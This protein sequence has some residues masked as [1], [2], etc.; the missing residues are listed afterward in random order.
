MI[1]Y[2]PKPTLI[3]LTQ[4]LFGELD[5][6]VRFITELKYNGDRLILQRKETGLFEF[7][8]RDG[9][10]LKYNPLD[11]LLEH[12]SSFKWEGYCVLDGELLHFKTKYI[13]HHVILFDA[14]I[15]NGE[16]L[17][18]KVFKERRAYVEKLFDDG[19]FLSSRSL[20]IDTI[21][22]IPDFRW[23]TSNGVSISPQ[24]ESGFK[25]IFNEFTKMDEIEGLVI[26]RLDAKLELGRSSS[27]VVKYMF[28][29]RKP[30]PT[31]R[32]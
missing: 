11:S 32:F 26:K 23:D 20:P 5:K 15:W 6:D 10:K 29:V 18:S 8:N 3:S 9:S 1:F 24:W 2:P 4:P 16:S 13:K 17:K 25:K 19:N 22:A 28:K 12:L 30:G 31:Y 27:P 7:W 21:L 14:F